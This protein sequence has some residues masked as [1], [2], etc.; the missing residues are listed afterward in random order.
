MTH[1]ERHGDTMVSVEVKTASAIIDFDDI[2]EKCEVIPDEYADAPWDNCDGFDYELRPL[3]YY[4]HD[5]VR[6]SRACVW[7]DRSRKLIELSPKDDFDY[8]YHR[9][10]GATR[11][12][13]AE[14]AACRKRDILDT[15]RKWHEDGWEHWGVRCEFEVC[16]Q[17]FEASCWGIDDSD[18][19]ETEVK[20]DIAGE[21]AAE[22]RKAGFDVINEPDS[23]YDYKAGRIQ[24]IRWGLNQQNW[25]D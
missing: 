4:D 9:K 22:L 25:R 16:G 17:S 24:A 19:A 12:V 18:Y 11:Q 23:Q 6:E 10:N 7:S 8:A 15:I 20:R 1:V 13:A 21:V 5:G 3:G 2:L 14:L